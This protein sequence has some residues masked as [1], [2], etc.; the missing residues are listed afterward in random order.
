MDW[1]GTLATVCLTVAPMW[2]EGV[3]V[4]FVTQIRIVRPLF[5][6]ETIL[7]L[8]SLLLLLQLLFLVRTLVGASYCLLR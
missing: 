2:Q 3:R 6:G 8:W 5:A 4:I 7:L 1:R